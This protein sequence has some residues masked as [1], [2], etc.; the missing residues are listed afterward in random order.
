MK[1][2]DDM[3]GTREYEDLNKNLEMVDGHAVK[4]PEDYQ[5]PE[6]LYQALI[7][8]V[9]KYHPSADI[10]MIEK[11][12]QIGKEAHKDQ[13]RKSGEPYI[14]HPLWV[15]IILADLE[16]DKETIVAGMLH[17]VVEDTT[18]TL[19]E[20]STEFGEEVALLVDGVTKLGQLNY[21][22]DK[23]EAQ[24][25]NLRKMFLAMA[26]DIRVIIVKLADRLHN[27]RTMEFMTPAKQKEKSRE[28]M[29]IYAP[30]AQRLGISKIKT[31]LDDLSLKYYQ[32]EVYNQLVHDLNARKTERE[33][34]V[35]QIVAEVSKHMKN[36][37]IEAK[38]YGRV[39]HFFSIYKKMVNQNKTLDQ[40]YDLFAVRII[41]DSV[42]DCYAALGVIHEM[43]T[44]IP[45]RFKDYIAMPKANMYQSLHTT[46]IGPSG[47]PFEIQIRTEEMHKTAEYG[48]AAHW[49][50]KETGGS[51]TKGL[52]TQEEK[53][54]WLRQI[55]EWQRDMS[56]NREFLSLL[57]GDLD[58][59]Q[60]DVYCFTPNGDVKNLPNGS[61]PV[62][63]AY[64]IHTAVGNKMVGA[65]VNGK[66]VNID[67]KIQNGD[68]IEILTSQNS[69]GPSRDWL[70]IVKSTQ[71]K[72]K[73]NQ[74]FKKEFKEENIVRGKEM[75]AAYCKA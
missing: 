68:R 56:D 15:A 32:P 28:T 14:I 25:E 35:Q 75:L 42:K 10:T 18:M 70:S 38:V 20:I 21:S 26:K 23:L 22:K 34:F 2:E 58:L 29:D 46:L 59:F 62:D 52:N 24:A 67:Y 12:Y 63:F 60:E 31:E 53:L 49:K 48:I 39:K 43:Y 44:P 19:D 65:R 55:L 36:A 17:D 45:G 61:T 11:A 33:E 16:M 69:K 8:R 72:N 5:D 6:E 9:R 1:G 50:Y 71:A 37:D 40:V 13:F 64:A 74:W 4:A 66:L 7:A 27:M 73:I 3:A 41:V 57:K 47:Q 54:N 51:N 30:I